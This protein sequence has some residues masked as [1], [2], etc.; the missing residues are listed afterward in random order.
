MAGPGAFDDAI[1]AYAQWMGGPSRKTAYVAQEA[2]GNPRLQALLEEAATSDTPARVFARISA[3]FEPP[4]MDRAAAVYGGRGQ[5]GRRSAEEITR[6]G[7]S[8][9]LGPYFR[10]APMAQVNDAQSL[11]NPTMG[12]EDLIARLEGMTP[13]PQYMYDLLPDTSMQ[14]ELSD[15]TPG[16]MAS[17]NPQRAPE[18]D[19]MAAFR[20]DFER[21]G[22]RLAAEMSALGDDVAAQA[23]PSPPTAASTA[24]TLDAESRAYLR[25]AMDRASP[26]GADY[27][28]GDIGLPD[29]R[30]PRALDDIEVPARSPRGAAPSR[31][32]VSDNARTAATAAGIGALGV[33]ANLGMRQVVDQLPA[34]ARDPIGAMQGSSTADLAAETSPPPSVTTQEPAPIDYAQMARDKIR[35][36]NEIQLREG[37]ITPESA[38]LS[39]EADALYLR[40]AEGRRMGN[41]PPIMPVEQQDAQT[42]AIRARRGPE[43]ADPRSAARRILADL[44]AGRLPPAQR[45]A[46]Q[47]EMQRLYRLADDYD[48]ARRA[49]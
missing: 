45:A 3:E 22:D 27:L 31:P 16:Q 13:R 36:A 44:N 42:S 11:L 18:P 25:A 12:G 37:R 4:A 8:E 29:L 19:L 2:A 49:G 47:A 32:R 9:E 5:P 34:F 10:E 6:E 17:M 33:A 21:Q 28:R 35:Q 7:V 46:A 1:S 24:P 30:G 20:G 15:L 14:F 41:Q 48:N 23:A 38:A 43:G 39:R 26:R 40:A